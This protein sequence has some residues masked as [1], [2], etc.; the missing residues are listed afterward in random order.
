MN[1]NWQDMWAHAVV[2]AQRAE[3]A[4]DAAIER[5]ERAEAEVA[6]LQ[7]ERHKLII[8]V[9]DARAALDMYKERL[10]P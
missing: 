6:D 10:K 1:T 2:D 3:A 8:D 9:A 4:R 7:A 5:A